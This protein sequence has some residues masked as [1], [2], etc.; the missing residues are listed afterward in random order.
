MKTYARLDGNGY[1]VA[2]F[3]SQQPPADAIEYPES[4]PRLS[5]QRIRY[6]SGQFV[7]TDETWEPEPSYDLARVLAYPSL[8]D[9]MDMLW[10]AMDDNVIPRV[11]PFYSQI[12]AVKDAHPK[13]GM[14]P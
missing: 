8:G 13:P 9:Q 4:A 6:D 3:S 11:E 5:F 10:H 12:K 1:V 7:Q 14:T 2:T